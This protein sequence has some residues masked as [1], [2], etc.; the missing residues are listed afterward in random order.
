MIVVLSAT[1]QQQYAATRE[2]AH[3]WDAEKRH[4]YVYVYYIHVSKD[5]FTFI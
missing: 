1:E 3:R 5:A 2:S 4:P